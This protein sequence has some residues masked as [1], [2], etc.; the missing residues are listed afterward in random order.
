MEEAIG[1]SNA[2]Y[3]IESFSIV[4]INIIEGT[5]PN[6]TISDN[7]SNCP[8][9]EDFD[10]SIR[11]TPPSRKS[12]IRAMNRHI[13]AILKLVLYRSRAMQPNAKLPNVI[14]LGIFFLKSTIEKRNY[15]FSHVL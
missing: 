13:I 12:S 11:A 3:F 15:F 1:M 10:L 4:L 6:E 9:K 14:I 8:P 5:T 7:E 2:I